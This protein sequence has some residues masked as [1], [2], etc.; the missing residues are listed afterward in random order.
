MDMY[1]WDSYSPQE[2]SEKIKYWVDLWED[3]I[4]N[5]NKKLY[6]LDLINPQLLIRD[7]IDEINFNALRNK[8]N[9]EY[10]CKQLNMLL[11]KD[12]ALK[13]SFRTDFCLIKKELKTGGNFYLLQLCK[14]VQEIFRQ[15][16]YFEES[17]N[18][19]KETL[20]NPVWEGN[21]EEN[22]LLISQ[23]L[24]VEL[25]LRG[26][27]LNEI[28][29]FPRNLFDKYYVQNELLITNYPHDT[30]WTDFTCGES[31]DHTAFN[32]AVKAK[33]DALTVPK[34]LEQFSK[35]YYRKPERCYFI[36]QIEGL[37]GE[38]DFNIGN[39]N[40]YSPSIKKY[41]TEKSLLGYDHEYFNG[42]KNQ[43]FMNAAVPVDSMDTEASK[44]YAMETIEKALDLLRCFYLTK[45]NFEI[46]RENYLIVDSEGRAGF[47][48]SV[49]KRDRWYRWENALDLNK[50]EL[51]KDLLPELLARINKFLFIPREKQS[52]I[53]QKIVY[54]L[55]WYRKGEETNNLEDKLLHY[56][57]VIENLMNFKPSSINIVLPNNQR[58]RILRLAREL[59]PP[60][61]VRNFIYE[62]VTE[63]YEYLGRLLNSRQ[64]GR[65]YLTL[66]EELIEVCNLNPKPNT[67]ISLLPFVNNLGKVADAIDRKIIKKRVLSA[68]SFYMDNHFAKEQIRKQV[69]QVRDDILLIYRYRNKIVHHAHYDLS[70]LPYFVQKVR[71]FA[72]DLLRE[73][74]HE[75]SVSGA[76]SVEE[77]LVASY[78]K[79]NRVIE[80]LNQNIP[81][82]FL[83]LDL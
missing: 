13:K 26:Y 45:T 36:F 65:P 4:D 80:K 72:G 44:S 7:L 3:L 60:I 19:L 24:I 5:F 22:I 57:I 79:M 53:E 37:K 56:W 41:V 59:L 75:S 39:V 47:G 68:H 43:Y 10:F 30:K 58:E 35:Y 81:V 50:H 74:L 9:R 54:S 33:I 76:N 14:M 71:K 23:H 15:G 34:R 28:H 48:G 42:D 12:L 66:P 70:V 31:F 25:L 62:L 38:K 67:Q 77:I 51:D 63:L 69:E 32:K 2:I 27:S 82:D 46:V 73:I 29:S 83:D 55:H 78:V 52:D 1:I 11:N 8:D 18:A 6:G 64:G 16:K 61:Q 20:L 17:Y 40:F 49:S 21:D